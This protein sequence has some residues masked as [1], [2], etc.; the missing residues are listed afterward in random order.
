MLWDRKR[1]LGYVGTI[2]LMLGVTDKKF[3]EASLNTTL[4][5]ERNTKALIRLRGSAGWSAAL[6]SQLAKSFSLVEAHMKY[7][8]KSYTLAHT[9]DDHNFST[10]AR[11]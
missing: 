10:R 11:N 3:Y 5:S 9:S 1:L 6:F 4:C 7:I 2:Q 8:F